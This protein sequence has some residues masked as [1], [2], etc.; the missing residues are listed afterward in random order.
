MAQKKAKTT[1]QVSVNLKT[2]MQAKGVYPAMGPDMVYFDGAS[3]DRHFTHGQWQDGS[4][5]TLNI[6]PSGVDT[7]FI[8]PNDNNLTRQWT[9]REMFE[10]IGAYPGVQNYQFEPSGNQWRYFI[11][12]NNITYEATNANQA[13][14]CA[15]AFTNM[16]NAV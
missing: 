6:L 4:F 14:A 8:D 10:Q 11:I 15:I 12:R 13:D 7:D 9:V 1:F 5:R 3:N 2:A 16:L